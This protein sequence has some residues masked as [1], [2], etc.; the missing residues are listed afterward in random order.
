M[1]VNIPGALI[2]AAAKLH[3]LTSSALCPSFSGPGVSGSPSLGLSSACR[4]HRVPWA[5]PFATSH[6]HGW[7]G[8]GHGRPS[9]ER[10]LARWGPHL[11]A[12]RPHSPPTLVTHS[13]GHR[14]WWSR[15]RAGRL[16]CIHAPDARG[17]ADTQVPL[18]P[19]AKACPQKAGPCL[20]TRAG[21]VRR[22]SRCLSVPA[23]PS[24]FPDLWQDSL[25]WV[26]GR[27]EQDG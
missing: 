16:W 3:L 22:P 7:W 23:A 18:S 2:T 27:G 1:F 10:G 12:P 20:H 13:W 9:L 5:C 4:T 14:S 19:T 21:I 11:E 17:W 24:S 26:S 6:C 15:P 8:G 25:W